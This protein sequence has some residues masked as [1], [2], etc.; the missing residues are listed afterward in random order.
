MDEIFHGVSGIS[1]KMF[2]KITL[3]LWKYF[4]KNIGRF[5]VYFAKINFRIRKILRKFHVIVE[6]ILGWLRK[7]F[8]WSWKVMKKCKDSLR[9][10]KSV[11][12][13][14][15]F[16]KLLIILRE[17]LRK[18]LKKRKLNF[19]EIRWSKKINDFKEIKKITRS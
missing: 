6:E 18:I 7:I 4:G 10:R 3:K 14:G 5:R 2:S 9:T 16:Q 1:I 8:D 13:S 17:T 12:F 19:E 15:K 11:K